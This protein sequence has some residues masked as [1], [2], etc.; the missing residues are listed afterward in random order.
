MPEQGTKQTS[1]KERRPSGRRF[2]LSDQSGLDQGWAGT[3]TAE[4]AAFR[5][6]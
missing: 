2:L 4:A 3:G 1:H 6:A 5:A